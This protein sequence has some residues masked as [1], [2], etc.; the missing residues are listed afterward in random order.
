MTGALDTQVA[1]DHYKKMKIQPIEFSYHNKIP[2]IESHIIK[3]VCR[4]TFK[5]GKEDLNK[6]IHLLEILKELEYGND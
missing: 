3:Y 1:G 6:A 5:N 4:H 2:A